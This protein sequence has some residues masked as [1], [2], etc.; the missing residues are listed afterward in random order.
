MMNIEISQVTF[1]KDMYGNGS[2][3]WFAQISRPNLYTILCDDSL[4]RLQATVNA[5]FPRFT[6]TYISDNTREF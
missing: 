2:K 4:E 3:K 5:L 6:F 1:I